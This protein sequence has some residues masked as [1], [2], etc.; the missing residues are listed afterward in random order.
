MQPTAVRS[1]ECRLS[2]GGSRVVKVPCS[3]VP[4][5]AA[6]SGNAFLVPHTAWLRTPESRPTQR[7]HRIQAPPKSTTVLFA[8]SLESQYRLSSCN[9]IQQHAQSQVS[10]LGL[11]TQACFGLRFRS[12]QPSRGALLGSWDTPP[13]RG[14]PN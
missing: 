1:T 10:C 12:A 14:S 9:L 3:S 5:A 4:L 8:T 13:S 2:C 7:S 11:P 6:A